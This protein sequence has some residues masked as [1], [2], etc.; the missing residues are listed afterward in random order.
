NVQVLDH[1]YTEI[2]LPPLGSI[3]A[4]THNTPLKFTITLTNIDI[5]GIKSLLE[6]EST[7]ED[8]EKLTNQ[9]REDIGNVV[10]RYIVRLVLLAAAGGGIA[11]ALLRPKKRLVIL[12]GIMLGALIVGGTLWQTYRT[13]DYNQFENPEFQGVLEVAPWMISFAQEAIVKVDELGN[14]LQ[15]IAENLFQVYQ[16]IES[17]DLREPIDSNLRILHVS[18]IHNN[19]AAFEFVR[20][21]AVSFNADYII[22]TGDETDFGTPLENIIFQQISELGIP[23]I[24][25]GGNHDSE[26]TLNAMAQIDNVIILDKEAIEIGGL[27]LIGFSDPYSKTNLLTS[28]GPEEVNEN[29]I[30]IQQVLKAKDILPDMV[31]VHNHRL[32]NQLA[33]IVPVIFHGHDHRV[34]ISEVNN[35]IILDA[36][37]SGAAGIRGLQTVNETPYSVLMLYFKVT[38]EEKSLTAVDVFKVYNLRS[39]FILERNI[40]NYVLHETVE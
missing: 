31:A 7:T 27:T 38:E 10:F 4:K 32:G 14:R 29:T 19:P 30:M 15:I 6:A 25:I 18:D 40:L 17:L 22:D 2:N 3:R 20:Q 35:S 21:I 12:V 24:F 9:I 11:V 23:F 16:T 39:G 1:G 37:T 33:G 26:D 28:L 34:S 5:N 13:Y 8:F 36:G